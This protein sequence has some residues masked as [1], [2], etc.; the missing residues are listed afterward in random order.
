MTLRIFDT[1]RLRKRAF[2]NRSRLVKMFLCGPTIYD[3]CHIGHARTFV[4]FDTIVRYLQHQG[5][6]T[7]VVMNVTDISKEI[8]QN[9]KNAGQFSKDYADHYFQSFLEDMSA[10]GIETVDVYA[11]ASDRIPEMIDWITKL[12]EKGV[13][14]VTD[15]GV[16]L[17]TTKVKGYGQLSHQ[18]KSEIALRRLNLSPAKK[19]PEDFSVWN[20]LLADRDTWDSPWGRGRPGEH[21]EDAAACIKH[22]DIPYD[23]N[24]GGDELIF[25]HHEATKAQLEGVTGTSVCRYWLHT[26]LLYIKGRK[27][28]KSLGN[29]VTIR[30]ILTQYDAPILRLFFSL[31]P[32][33]K[34]IHFRRSDL[35]RAARLSRILRRRLT[36]LRGAAGHN[37]SEKSSYN[38]DIA[39]TRFHDRFVKAMDDDFDTE[40]AVRHVIEFADRLTRDAHLKKKGHG[41]SR[42]LEVLTE[43]CDILGLL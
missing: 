12:L 16:Y 43:L 34:P 22:L 35:E 32:Y 25:P 5:Y 15:E 21:I 41:Y 3:Y 42:A 17:D 6:K 19:H 20:N 2:T 33:R 8:S 29:S 27:M 26:G 39:C 1:L 24:G 36:E 40:T 23:I 18:S 13:A 14:Y 31:T 38:A 4:A 7:R 11:R 9:A 10:L 37:H 28:S 30:D